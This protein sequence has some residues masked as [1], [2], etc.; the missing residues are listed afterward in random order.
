MTE[1]NVTDEIEE[2]NDEAIY[3]YINALKEFIK[4]KDH[5]RCVKWKDWLL[6]N[7]VMRSWYMHDVDLN[8][9]IRTV[10]NTGMKAGQSFDDVAGILRNIFN[11]PATISYSYNPKTI[12][13]RIGLHF[14]R[15][16]KNLVYRL[17]EYRFVLAQRC[18]EVTLQDCSSKAE[19][20]QHCYAEALADRRGFMRKYALSY[21]QSIVLHGSN[22]IRNKI[23]YNL[24]TELVNKFSDYF[25]E[26]FF[27]ALV[28]DL[29][30]YL[31]Y[32]YSPE[33]TIMILYC[34]ISGSIDYKEGII[35]DVAAANLKEV[36]LN[37]FQLLK[38]DH[39]K[40]KNKISTILYSTQSAELKANK[41]IGVL[42]VINDVG[43][44]AT[45]YF[46]TD[47]ILSA[48]SKRPYD[49]G[50]SKIIYSLN[51]FSKSESV[52]SLKTI[53]SV[54]SGN[55]GVINRYYFKAPKN[56]AELSQQ[57]HRIQI[58]SV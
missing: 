20:D 26:I 7:I 37:A 41:M 2:K 48:L 30:F 51:N 52:L 15:L 36:M 22:S 56:N 28:C 47:K 35:D 44:E 42:Q 24:N 39:E 38:R 46:V 4:T 17:T 34:I 57:S 5:I 6:P 12:F 23:S 1:S 53:L 21:L 3:V 55:E 13:S 14:R 19:F 49:P 27:N 32:G 40:I 54:P 33:T 11:A 16:K 50:L 45:R 18:F 43:P 8:N 9:S 31:R 10:I 29:N 58:S 25:F